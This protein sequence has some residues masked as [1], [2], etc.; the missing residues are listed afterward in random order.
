MQKYIA[1]TLI[2][3]KQIRVLVY[4]WRETVNGGWACRSQL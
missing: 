4:G 3:T 2:S 1:F